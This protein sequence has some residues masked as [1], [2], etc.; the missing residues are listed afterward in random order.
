MLK[1]YL[2]NGE[3]LA[4]NITIR[5]TNKNICLRVKNNVIAISMPYLVNDKEIIKLLTKN[6][7]AI[8]SRIKPNNQIHYMGRLYDVEIIE[9][10]HNAVMF[11]DKVVIYTRSLDN[12]YIHKLLKKAYVEET[13]KLTK[14]YIN[15]ALE[16]FKAD[17]KGPIEVKFRYMTSAYGKCYSKREEIVLSGMCAKLEPSLIKLVVFHEFCHLKYLAH[18]DYFYSYLESKMEDAMILTKMLRKIKVIDFFD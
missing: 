17:Y 3:I 5:K 10:K 1:E 15:E 6:Y 18:N 2:I 4:V 7:E 13:K 12:S 16:V 14:T 8:K 9:S 11:L